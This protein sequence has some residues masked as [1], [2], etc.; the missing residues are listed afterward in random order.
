MVNLP[1]ETVIEAFIS[2]ALGDLATWISPSTRK[3]VGPRSPKVFEDFA[4]KLAKFNKDARTALDSGLYDGI[5][6]FGSEP[7]AVGY[8]P[9]LDR[10]GVLHQLAD[11]L[12]EIKRACPPWFAGG[13][14]VYGHRPDWKH[15]ASSKRLTLEEATLLLVDVEPRNAS[16][17]EFFSRYG[18]H[19]SGDEMI[20]FLEDRYYELARGLDVDDDPEVCLSTETLFA[21]VARKGIDIPKE[22]QAEFAHYLSMP[23][24]QIDQV[25]LNGAEVKNHEEPAHGRSIQMFQR[26]IATMAVARFGMKSEKEAGKIA[27]L[28]ESEGLQLGFSPTSRRI[29]MHL[30]AG[31]K[32]IT[33]EVRDDL[34]NDLKI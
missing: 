28:I 32:Q 5:L 22:A 31:F 13:W 11:E 8:N 30:R 24:V 19:P 26:I 14:S 15:W 1:R 18:E 17:D 23:P 29:S 33:D 9:L 2:Q 10:D 12:A 7:S 34:K 27:K 6:D 3:C 20:Y 21:W 25:D 4:G 16:V